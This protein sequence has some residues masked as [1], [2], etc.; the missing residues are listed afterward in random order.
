MDRLR[1]LLLAPDANPETISA[2]L[3]GYR[4]AEAL[5]RL[6]SVTLVARTYNE[7]ILRR[8]QAPFQAIEAIACH[9]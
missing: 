9:G 1:I 6:H 2:N 5:A 3:V 7:E 8:T 4:H